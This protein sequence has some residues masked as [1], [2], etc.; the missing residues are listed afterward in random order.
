MNIW[1]RPQSDPAHRAIA[2]VFPFL[3]DVL[4]RSPVL[5]RQVR[6]PDPGGLQALLDR[7]RLRLLRDH[8]HPADGH[9]QDEDPAERGLRW[10][11]QPSLDH[12]PV[13]S[14]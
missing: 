9:G 3:I 10:R 4:V 2:A 6:Q 7:L 12:Q 5:R 8:L 13:A 1:A 11:D 14:Q